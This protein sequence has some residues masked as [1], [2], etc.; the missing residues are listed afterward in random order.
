MTPDKAHVRTYFGK[1]GLD[2]E[3]ADIYLALYV[4][5]P[6]TISQLA[7][8][9]GVERTK[10]YR[11]IDD[12]LESNLVE[13]E[14]HAKRGIIKAAPIANLRILIAQKEQDLKSLQDELGL[15]EQVLGRNSLSSPASRVQFYQGTEGYKQMLWNEAKAKT[16]VCSI[17]YQIAQDKTTQTFFDR[18]IEQANT[19]D[20][21]YRALY[22][23]RFIQSEREWYDKHENR[24]P[25]HYDARYLPPN[26]MPVTYSQSVYDN[27]TA[28]FNWKDDEI[29]GI[30]IYNQQIADTHRRLFDLLWDQSKAQK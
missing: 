28:I 6:Q 15:I 7:R 21:H 22:G 13:L 4:K 20:V 29:F 11:L 8:S 12:L 3:V 27:I 1:L 10:I 16:E 26:I 17:T 9:S 14:N 25:K 24:K 5:G 19:N 30:E 2:Q 23:D 18:F